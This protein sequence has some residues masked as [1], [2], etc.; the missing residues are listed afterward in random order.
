[1]KD[2]KTRSVLATSRTCR[3]KLRRARVY[4][5]DLKQIAVLKKRVASADQADGGV[6]R[7]EA[8]GAGVGE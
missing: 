6:A 8:H 4:V 7:E 2:E 1:M 5:D 3:S